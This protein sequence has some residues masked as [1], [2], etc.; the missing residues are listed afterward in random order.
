MYSGE[1]A[2]VSQLVGGKR[3]YHGCGLISG[4]CKELAFDS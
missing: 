3:N 1:E 2:R 4:W